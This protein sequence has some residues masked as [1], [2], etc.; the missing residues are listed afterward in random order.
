MVDMASRASAP[1]GAPVGPAEAPA[2]EPLA[3]LSDRR[4]AEA[5]RQIRDGDVFLFRGRRL[6][7]YAICWLTRSKYSHAGIAAWW[8]QRLMVL[9][10]DEP[11][12][13][14]V[15]LSA[16]VKRYVGG[17]EWWTTDAEVDRAKVVDAAKQ[18]LG[19]KFAVW[20]MVA[21]LRRV[22]GRVRRGEHDPERAPAEF[23][24]AQF[25]SYAYNKGG[26]DLAPRVPDSLTEPGDIARALGMRRVAVLK[27]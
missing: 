3:R 6:L 26:L 23:F 1:A 17:I 11:G 15:P 19:R 22:I 27:R 21:V 24:C 4:Y 7:S 20:A 14:A 18:C 13:V 5:R 10:A 2:T 12:V 9:E 16:C 25:V 8:G